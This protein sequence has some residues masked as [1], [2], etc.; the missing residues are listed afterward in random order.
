MRRRPPHWET[1]TKKE[2]TIVGTLGGEYRGG[3]G[4]FSKQRKK[5]KR[6]TWMERGGFERKGERLM[7]RGKKRE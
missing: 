2:E 4:E 6:D 7:F 5:M 3:P 1:E